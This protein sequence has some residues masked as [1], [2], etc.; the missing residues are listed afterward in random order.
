MERLNGLDLFSGI[1]GITKALEEWVRPIAYCERDR[2]AQA[3]LFSRMQ[4]GDLSVAPIWDDVQSLPADLPTEGIDII[5]GGF[6]CQDISVAG[7][8][9][10]LEGQRSGLFFEVVRLAKEIKPAFVFLENV[11]A[12]RTRGLDR[13]IQEFTEVG[14]DVRWTMLSAAD[15]GANH[16]RERWFLLA[17]SSS[18]TRRI[19]H[20]NGE[21]DVSD[22]TSEQS[23]RLQQSRLQSDFGISGQDVANAK[24]HDKWRTRKTSRQQQISPGRRGTQSNAVADTSGQSNPQEGSSTGT[25]GSKKRTRN[26]DGRR[27][28]QTSSRNDWWL[29]EPAVGRVVDGVPDRVDRLKCLGNAVVPQ[30]AK[31]AFKILMG[32]K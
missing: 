6:P 10:G 16:K 3:V 13:V 17:Y 28:G 27:N 23:G 2:Y 25:I 5:Y 31:E 11:P 32:L 29:L 15:V 24:S 26:H 30:Q 20:R 1:G 18:N 8:G 21:N 7:C 12:I 9:K 4:S 14:Y 22:S 19:S